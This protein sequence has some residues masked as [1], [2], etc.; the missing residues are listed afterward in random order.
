MGFLTACFSVRLPPALNIIRHYVV[1]DQYVRSRRGLSHL[2]NL[3]FLSVP[4]LPPHA[5]PVVL[6]S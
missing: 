2:T 6:R 4:V 1:L 5:A 3:A